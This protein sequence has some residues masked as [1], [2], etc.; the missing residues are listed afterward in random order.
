MAGVSAAGATVS[1]KLNSQAGFLLPDAVVVNCDS[2][3][4]YP[5]YIEDH[6]L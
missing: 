3:K 2:L 6:E 5:V 1:P 4:E